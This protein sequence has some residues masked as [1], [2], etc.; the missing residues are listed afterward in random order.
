VVPDG[1]RRVR[2]S[3]FNTAT[4]SIIDSATFDGDP[5]VDA[6]VTVQKVAPG[7]QACDSNIQ[8]V[9]Q[10]MIP[11]TITTAERQWVSTACAIKLDYI[12]NIGGA[13]G[14]IVSA[15]LF[16]SHK[17]KSVTLTGGQFRMYHHHGVAG[18]MPAQ[19]PDGIFNLLQPTGDGT[20]ELPPDQYFAIDNNPA[21]PSS[22]FNYGVS[23]DD[24]TPPFNGNASDRIVWGI[25]NA[26][27][28]G[29]GSYDCAPN[30]KLSM[31]VEV[32]QYSNELV[33]ESD[34][35]NSDND[36]SCTVTITKQSGRLYAAHYT[37]TLVG[38][39]GTPALLSTAQRTLHLAGRFRNFIIVPIAAGNQGNE[40]NLPDTGA[41]TTLHIDDGNTVF[42]KGQQFVLGASSGAVPATG[43]YSLVF[44]RTLP[45]NTAPND[46]IRKS[47][48][49]NLTQVPHGT[50]TFNCGDTGSFF[51]IAVRTAQGIDYGYASN[52]A[53]TSCSV[54][55][56]SFDAQ[57]VT[58]HYSA[59]LR[60]ADA[61]AFLPGGDATI[62]VSGQF[63]Q[64]VQQQ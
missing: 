55:I 23:P 29:P 30:N 8:I 62:T 58:G 42:T 52:V 45:F 17:N 3:N 5:V 37:A 28:N 34:N 7:T 4:N 36:G 13:T 49:V 27:F 12:S 47:V 57:T 25:Q 50:G 53:G 1:Y 46:K 2:A 38:I 63:R 19:L 10:T 32:G 24:G 35:I 39:D 9:I 48:S 59:V 6:T 51:A 64:A 61:E 40:G 18:D 41:A 31:F 56:D 11:N 26:S 20:F 21:P 14:T 54:T 16:N 22:G 60:N 44:Q 43:A 15:T 33:Y